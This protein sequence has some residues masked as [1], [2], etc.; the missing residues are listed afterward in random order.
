MKQCKKNLERLLGTVAAVM[1]CISR[2]AA[3]S[4]HGG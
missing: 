3:G 2:S 4:G 1:L